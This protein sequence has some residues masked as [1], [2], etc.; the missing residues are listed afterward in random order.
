MHVAEL[1]EHPELEPQFF[2]ALAPQRGQ[3][4]R[5]GDV[6]N[7]ALR[8]DFLRTVHAVAPFDHQHLGFDVSIF[9]PNH[10]DATWLYCAFC[11]IC[12][13]FICERWMEGLLS[14]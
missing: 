13:R 5:K 7:A 10:D 9:G 3:K 11:N 1:I 14:V 12:L 4:Q 6:T 2:A 8:D